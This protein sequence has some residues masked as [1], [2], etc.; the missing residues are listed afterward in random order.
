MTVHKL[1]PPPNRVEV[2]AWLRENLQVLKPFLPPLQ[3]GAIGWFIEW[4]ED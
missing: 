4:L 3:S 2:I 1:A